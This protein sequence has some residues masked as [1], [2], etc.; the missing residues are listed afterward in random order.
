MTGLVDRDQLISL[1]IAEFWGVG[2]LPMGEAGGV[3]VGA[4]ARRVADLLDAAGFAVVE[5]PEVAC[6]G[7][8]GLDVVVASTGD[9]FLPLVEGRLAPREY[10]EMDDW[11]FNSLDEAER[12]ALRV[13]AVV[14]EL[15]AIQREQH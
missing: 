12:D 13:L 3:D 11:N 9:E 4:L 10:V 8:G 15:R 2:T 5:L 6:F 14:R 1:V 7:P